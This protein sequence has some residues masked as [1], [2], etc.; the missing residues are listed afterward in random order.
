MKN[1]KV[2]FHEVFT[3][4]MT[5]SRDGDCG[6]RVGLPLVLVHTV[7]AVLVARELFA[8]QNSLLRQ[9]NESLLSKGGKIH[10]S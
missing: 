7:S 3:T 6:G 10:V 2:P 8:T 4:C 9:L 5:S 1:P